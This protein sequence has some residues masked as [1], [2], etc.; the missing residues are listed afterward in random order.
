MISSV[1]SYA[2]A[3]LAVLGYQEW[4]DGFNFEN[5]PK[6]R[7]DSVF[8]LTLG[9]SLGTDIGQDNQ[10]IE[11]PFT[12]RLFLAPNRNPKALIDQATQ[13]ADIVIADLLKASNRLTQ[14]GIKTVWFNTMAIEPI[15]NSNDNGV[16]IQFN[17]TALVVI[18]TR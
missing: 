10:T 4:T 17:F 3:R 16:I 15:A 5:I 18:S 12:I 6:T 2:R 9:D 7:L 14:T 13:I 1:L 11:T 8:H